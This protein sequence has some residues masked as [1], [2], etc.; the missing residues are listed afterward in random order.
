MKHITYHASHNQ[1][2]IM[3]RRGQQFFNMETKSLDEAKTIR[4]KV[5][6][7]YEEHK[8]LPTRQ[9][10][11]IAN[12]RQGG[13]GLYNVK[14]RTVCNEVCSKCGNDVT[15]KS[16]KAYQN[17]L[18]SNKE[19]LNCRRV[20]GHRETWGRSKMFNITFDES[21]GAK[22]YR[23]SLFRNGELFY[24]HLNTLE[25]AI[26][27]R[28]KALEFYKQNGRLPNEEECVEQFGIRTKGNTRSSDSNIFKYTNS[29]YYEVKISR[30]RKMYVSRHETFSEA[31]LYRDKV[32]EYY[33]AHK[34]L[35]TVEQ[36][37]HLIE[38]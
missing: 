27:T 6:A 32:I 28:D 4:D 37:K 14:P 15:Y 13:T 22:P 8:N 7:Y 36:V 38:S 29:K 9:Q 18:D 3:V 25:D 31:Q 23:V 16:K 19:C 10:I 17:Y 2:K 33:D 1:Y 21:R 5:L 35:P 30:N 24:Q 12:G 34:S 26:A 11:G 20:D